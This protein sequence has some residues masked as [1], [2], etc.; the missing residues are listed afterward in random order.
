MGVLRAMIK[1][2]VLLPSS[3]LYF[4]FVFASSWHKG[5]HQAT[6]KFFFRLGLLIFGVKVSRDFNHVL[7][8]KTLFIAN[9]ASYLDVFVFGAFLPVKFTP[10]SEVKGWPFIG[11]IVKVSGA[12]FIDRRPS[13]I[14][15][16]IDKMLKSSCEGHG[17]MLFPEGTTSNG[18]EILPFKSGLFHL[19]FSDADIQIT[20]VMIKYTKLN[21]EVVKQAELDQI[22]WYADM[23]LSPHFWNLLKQRSI[24][25]KLVTFAPVYPRGFKDRKSLA[26]HCEYVLR[27]KFGRA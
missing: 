17:L 15:D 20:P 10:K 5:L 18:S 9:H 1:S 13:K 6:M 22:A 12:V 3:L 21:G 26:S 24:E 7:S 27:S 8:D 25:V 14:R 23:T 19:A 2:A 4:V 16:Q 11:P